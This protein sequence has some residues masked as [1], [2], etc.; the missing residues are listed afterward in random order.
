MRPKERFLNCSVGLVLEAVSAAAF[1][2][3]SLPFSQPL[4]HSLFP[5]P[6]VSTM[7]RSSEFSADVHK[8]FLAGLD[9]FHPSRLSTEDDIA[10]AVHVLEGCLDDESIGP[11]I[12]C[13]VQPEHP[14]VF[15]FI[16]SSISEDSSKLVSQHILDRF[17]S[18]AEGFRASLGYQVLSRLSHSLSRP[19]YTSGQQPCL[20]KD[21]RL[22]ARGYLDGAEA[23]SKANKR[24]LQRGK[25][26]RSKV[27]S[28][29]HSEIND[30]LFQALGREAPRNRESAEESIRSI[31]ATQKVTLKFFATLLRTPDAARLV[32]RSYFRENVNWT[33]PSLANT[34]DSIRADLYFESAAGHG[35]WRILCPEP[36][37]RDLARDG[38]QSRSVLK[39]LE[40]LSLGCFSETNQ[41]RLTRD[42]PIEI[43]RARL[44]G[45]VRLVYHVDIIHEFGKDV[46]L[47]FSSS[48]SKLLSACGIVRNPRSCH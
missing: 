39:R 38:A 27:T 22:V 5:S 42:S 24:T 16:V 25:N 40:E 13:S 12:L 10:L 28:V 6:S 36:F 11:I 30:R 20:L 18:D 21:Y 45:N 43:Y 48:L 26:Q 4:L 23:E 31:I 3:I 17:P 2:W 32:R 8:Q 14:Y 19:P 33:I 41:L 46:R 37:L 47:I 9:I 1:T 34:A 44:P 7:S 29:A 35:K 15:E